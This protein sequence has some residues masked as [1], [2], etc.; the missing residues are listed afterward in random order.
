M[1][2]LSA[3]TR[4]DQVWTVLFKAPVHIDHAIVQ[5]DIQFGEH[6]QRFAIDVLLSPSGG[7]AI[8]VYAGESV[9]HKAICRFPLATAH[10]LRLRVTAA[11]GDVRLRALDL[12]HSGG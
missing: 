12:F 4:D 8:Q 7:P 10:G 9:G 3:F 5:E 11:D 1:A 2:D 6:I